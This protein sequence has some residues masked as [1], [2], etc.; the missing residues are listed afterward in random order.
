MPPIPASEPP[1]RRQPPW[2][3]LAVWLS[4]AYVSFHLAAGVVGFVLKVLPYLFTAAGAYF[5]VLLFLYV[6]WR[7]ELHLDYKDSEVNYHID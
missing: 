1:H 3:L 2:L 5:L 4:L 7:I 6:L